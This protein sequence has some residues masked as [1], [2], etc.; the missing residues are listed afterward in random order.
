M[1]CVTGGTGTIGRELV[2]QLVARNAAFVVT[3]RDPGAAR[4]R[5]GA[6]VPVVHGDFTDA[7]GMRTVFRQV[8]RLFLVCTPDLGMD[9]L[10]CAAVEAAKDSAVRHIVKISAPGADVNAPCELM[11][12]HG[13]I[14]SAIEESGIHWTHLRPSGFMQNLWGP[15][16][17][18]RS[19]AT[20][21]LSVGDAP[22]PFVDSAD[23]AAVALEC[24]MSPEAHR[25][26]AY[27][28]TGSEALTY[29][30]IASIFQTAL[31]VPVSYHSLSSD[32][33]RQLYLADGVPPGL[34]EELVGYFELMSQGFGGQVTTV[35]EDCTGRP[36][37]RLRQ[38]ITENISRFRAIIGN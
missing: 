10:E 29:A 36:P 28:V 34:V 38:F 31:G 37:K 32:E 16:Q 4:A 7:E 35:V 6:H 8:D 18:I 27:H 2:K 20:F 15:T 23:I 13:R 30:Q 25:N 1:I 22:V 19:D 17:G 26:R 24:L 21:R 5:L 11:R 33:A 12:V 9:R 3:S 14:E